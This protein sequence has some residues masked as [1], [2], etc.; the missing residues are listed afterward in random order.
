MFIRYSTEADASSIKEL[1][2]SNFG[3]FKEEMIANLSKR[4][5]LALDNNKPVAITGLYYS[6]VYKAL[7]VDWT[8][9][10]KQYRHKGLITELMKRL[11]QST[12]EDV[13][14]S[15]WRIADREINLYS[16]MKALG[17]E[18][19]IRFKSSYLRNVNCLSNTCIHSTENCK[20]YEDLYLIK[21]RG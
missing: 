7:E 16:S 9:C 6:N 20:C 14:C 8:S 13:Y 18:E 21:K 3:F 17:F 5:L 15:C 1:L 10:A 19:L 12:D 11:V 2:E 4:Y